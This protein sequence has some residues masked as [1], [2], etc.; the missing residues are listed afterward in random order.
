MVHALKNI[1]V[2]LWIAVVAGGLAALGLLA[3]LGSPLKPSFNLAVAAVVV[4]LAFLG[5]GWVFNRIAALRIQ[6]CLREATSRE[7]TARIGEAGEA[8]RKAVMVFDSFM[9]SPLLRKRTGRE[10][11]ARV[12][13]FHIARA[14]RNPEADAFLASYLWENPDDGEV[15]EYWLQHARPAEGAG[16]DQLALADR[17]AAAQ[18]ENLTIH[19][20]IAEM[21]LAKRRTDYTALRTYERLLHASD[22]AQGMTVSRLADLFLEEGRADEWAL[23]VYL[24]A[25]SQ[26]PKRTDCLRGL[27]ACLEQVRKT[28]RNEPLLTASREALRTVDKETIRQ[29]QASF[30]RAAEPP[31]P[32]ETARA[33]RWHARIPGLIRRGFRD[34]LRAAGAAAAL[35]AGRIGNGLRALWESP[36]TRHAAKWAAVVVFAA[37]VLVSGIRTVTYMVGTREPPVEA[38]PAPKPEPQMAPSGRYTVQVAS[39]RNRPQAINLSRRLQQLGHPA[40]WGESQSS[41]DNV[42]YYVRISRFEDKQEARR[43]AEELKSKGV[44]DDFYIANYKAP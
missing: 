27:A 4:L 36:R 3:A 24:K 11:A 14:G 40:Y 31:A 30:R 37:V 29:W 15:A 35:S 26:D 22:H 23:G 16:A 43:F 5:C 10:L 17:L 19:S 32:G 8:F 6:D 25:L 42:W 20:L 28:D 18:P 21:Y 9:V 39:F 41:Q 7:R 44:I 34:V 33:A 38:P 13:R 1:A 2:R 12:A